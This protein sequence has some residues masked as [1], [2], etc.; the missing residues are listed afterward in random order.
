MTWW[1]SGRDLSGTETFGRPLPRFIQ[2]IQRVRD[3]S[4][5]FGQVH[6]ARN[7]YALSVVTW[8]GVDTV[9]VCGSNPHAPGI[10]YLSKVP[11]GACTRDSSS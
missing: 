8:D 7:D 2:F 1:P 3:F 5:R 11:R 4:N 9:G 6:G 10:F